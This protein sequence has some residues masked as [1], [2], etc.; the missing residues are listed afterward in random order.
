[1]AKLEIKH[2]KI[3]AGTAYPI[4]SAESSYSCLKNSV[5][6]NDLSATDVVLD[7]DTKN[8]Y[9]RV[10]PFN[11]DDLAVFNVGKVFDDSLGAVDAH[12]TIF[13]KV[14]VDEIG[15][16]DVA[17][18][19]L[20][21]QRFFEDLVSTPD[22]AV[23]HPSISK[24]SDF[25]MSEDSLFDT[26]KSLSDAPIL[27]ES[28][29]YDLST[30]RADIGVVTDLF[31]KSVSFIRGFDNDT[32]V[33]DIF[34]RI[35]S[36]ARGVSDSASLAENNTVS[37]GKSLF[38]TPTL[39]ETLSRSVVYER[40][41]AD[42]FSLDDITDVSAKV[43]DF[44]SNKTNVIGFSD[45]HSFGTS[46]L[47]TDLAIVSEDYVSLLSKPFNESL[48]ASDTDI[49]SLSKIRSDDFDI[50]DTFSRSVAFSRDPEES[51]SFTDL[52]QKTLAKLL[53]DSAS[54]SDQFNRL[55]NFNRPV[56][57]SVSFSSNATTSFQKS[58]NESVAF[59][60]SV[61]VQLLSLASSVLNAGSLNTSP[62]NN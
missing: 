3:K 43:K 26:V 36:Y 38:D 52:E 45:I 33:S 20:T 21:I 55:V 17:V 4:L 35:V 18:V 37:F 48:S 8:R 51:I 24:A 50:S 60:E 5:F 61:D 10:E 25:S 9:F 39:S 12:A 6:F 54:V 41:F 47:F 44:S 46:K 34:D 49:K 16:T 28:T 14:N 22:I 27:T 58:L 19:L 57:E 31:S 62:L 30:S 32:V 29:A 1:M 23:L 56:N 59:T 2:L 15:F 53:S 7:P 42:F 11:V 40:Q 13:G